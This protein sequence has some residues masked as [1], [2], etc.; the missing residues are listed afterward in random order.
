MTDHGETLPRCPWCK[1]L[2]KVQKQY[3]TG[4][5]PGGSL[6]RAVCTCGVSGPWAERTM[7]INAWGV[8]VFLVRDLDEPHRSAWPGMA[9]QRTKC[10]PE[11]EHFSQVEG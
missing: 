4:G 11:P 1:D 3:L 2:P 6:Y 10:P 5:G 7:A 8:L 9:E